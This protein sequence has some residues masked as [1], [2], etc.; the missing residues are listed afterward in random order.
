MRGHGI[1]YRAF[2]LQKYRLTGLDKG[3]AD[4][5]ADGKIKVKSGVT[6]KKFTDK[7]LV[8]SDGSELP[9]DVVVFA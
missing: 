1:H 6:L 4:L 3:G 7:S 8:L 9:A 5:I 2:N